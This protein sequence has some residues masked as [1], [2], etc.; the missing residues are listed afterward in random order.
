LRALWK[1]DIFGLLSCS[2]YTRIVDGND[3]NL[4]EIV[5]SLNSGREL[6]DSGNDGAGKTPNFSSAGA[7]A[8]G[9]RDFLMYRPPWNKRKIRMTA[10][11]IIPPIF[12]LKRASLVI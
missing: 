10:P 7:G 11:I 9:N 4:P 12:K 5:L 6:V 3:G 8:S 2:L 1:S